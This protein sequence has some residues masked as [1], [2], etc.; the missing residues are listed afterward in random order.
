M[1][2]GDAIDIFFGEKQLVGQ[3]H[4][5]R[6]RQRVST[7]FLYDPSYLAGGGMN[8]DPSLLLVAGAQYQD[9]LLGAFSDSA[10]DRW[11]RN[12]ITKAE[13]ARAREKGRVPRRL[14]DV[15]FLLGVSDNTRQGALRF[16]RQGEDRFLGEPSQVPKL[17]SLPALLRASDDV[18]ADGE[19][20]VA[21][22]HLLDTGTTGLGGARPKASVRLDDGALAIAKFPHAGDRWDVMAWEATMLDLLCA[23]GIQ[24][25]EHRLVSISRR[26]VLLVRRFDRC[27]AGKRRGYISAMTATGSRDGERLDYLD[28]VEVIRDIS[29]SPKKD[30]RELYNRVIA[31]V[32]LGNTD[33]HL[34][35]HGFLAAGNSWELSPAFDVNPHPDLYKTRATSI[36]GADVFPEEVEGL[37]ALA[38]ECGMAQDEARER[39]RRLHAVFSSWR[40]YARRNRIV[41]SEIT[42]MEESIAPRLASLQR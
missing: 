15:D 21:I 14:D 42:L 8:I 12:L 33:D 16:R 37:R 2:V 23:A 22:K 3:A 11:G 30:H 26:S 28:L 24:V 38:Q 39:R 5:I 13:R 36:M 27:A 4:F 19:G 7:T 17:I 20:T 9:G 40:E 10:P 32:A 18:V 6:Q 35:N 41:E 1:T 25:P 29:I 34:R 31:G